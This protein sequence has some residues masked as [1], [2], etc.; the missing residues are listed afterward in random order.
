MKYHENTQPNS[1]LNIQI[2]AIPTERWNVKNIALNIQIWIYMQANIV[3]HWI[4]PINAINMQITN[5]N[6]SLSLLLID[7]ISV[8]IVAWIRLTRRFTDPKDVLTAPFM[9]CH[10]MSICMIFAGFSRVTSS[11][12]SFASPKTSQCVNCRFNDTFRTAVKLSLFQLVRPTF[13][14]H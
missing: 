8:D 14:R 13:L 10:F 2:A 1:H 3:L 5:A 11:I 9:M 7:P 12:L 6:P 4:T